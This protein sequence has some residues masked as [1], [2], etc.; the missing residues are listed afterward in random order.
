[1]IPAIPAWLLYFLA[2]V[3]AFSLAAS[4]LLAFLAFMPAPNPAG[5][6]D[7][8]CDCPACEEQRKEWC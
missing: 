5:T 4:A 7:P 2:A 6:P 3:G 1:M 8:D